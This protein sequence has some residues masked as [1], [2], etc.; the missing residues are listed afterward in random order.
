MMELIEQDML[1]DR[2]VLKNQLVCDQRLKA[3]FVVDKEYIIEIDENILV[4]YKK[5]DDLRH[6][7]RARQADKIAKEHGYKGYIG[8]SLLEMEYH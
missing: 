7:A 4:N 2:E 5:G 6:M 8:V 3:S 1:A